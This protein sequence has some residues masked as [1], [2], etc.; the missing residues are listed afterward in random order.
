MLR[1]LGFTQAKANSEIRWA[2]LNTATLLRRHATLHDKLAAAM[3][4]G[5]SVASCV[6]LIEQHLST[7][8]EI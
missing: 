7:V 5:D 4:R 2:V 1:A 8:E 6:A 3:S